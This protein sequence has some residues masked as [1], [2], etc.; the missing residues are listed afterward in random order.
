MKGYSYTYTK[1]CAW[2]HRKFETRKKTTRFCSTECAGLA[3]REIWKEKRKAKAE[4]LGVTVE[5]LAAM[6]R[7]GKRVGMTNHPKHN[8]AYGKCPKTYKEI[9]AYNKAHQIADGWRR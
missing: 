7:S 1:S 2:C 5:E 9:Q 3:R 6:I 8:R 4:E